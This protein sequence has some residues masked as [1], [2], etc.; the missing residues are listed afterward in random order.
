MT[1]IMALLALSAQ[2]QGRD[3]DHAQLAERLE[4]LEDRYDTLTDTVRSI[5]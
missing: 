4:Q 2:L 1:D 5:R 3:T